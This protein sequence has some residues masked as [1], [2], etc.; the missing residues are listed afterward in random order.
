[1][2]ASHYSMDLTTGQ[3]FYFREK[4]TN[5]IRWEINPDDPNKLELN[6][7]GSMDGLK[8]SNA[9]NIYFGVGG[10]SPDNAKFINGT[11][12]TS[13]ED[14]TYTT[15]KELTV[16]T[17]AYG[18]SIEVF[19]NNANDAVAGA[20]TG[21]VLIFT[22]SAPSGLDTGYASLGYSAG[23]LDNGM[24]TDKNEDVT[25]IFSGSAGNLPLKHNRS[26]SLFMGDVV[27]SG[28]MAVGEWIYHEGQ[29]LNALTRTGI[30]LQDRSIKLMAA[31][32]E[33]VHADAAGSV[34]SFNINPN[35]GAVSFQAKGNGA[36]SSPIF[37]A[38]AH[39]TTN[40]AIF[41][42][43]FDVL[44][45]HLNP[46]NGDDVLLFFSGSVGSKYEPADDGTPAVRATALFGGDVYV[47][48]ALG[49][50]TIDLANLT[51]TNTNA[52]LRFYDANHYIQ[53][54]STNLMFRDDA[55]GTAKSLTQLASLAVS[56]DLFSV[57]RTAV[58][59]PNY[60]M[61]T[62]SFSFDSGFNGYSTNNPR[63]TNLVS[64]NNTGGGNSDVYFFV[65]GAIG[66]R[67]REPV[68]I[69]NQLNRRSIALFG[70]DV[71]ISGTITSDNTSFGGSLNT[72]YDTSDGGTSVAGGGKTIIADAGYIEIKKTVSLPI[73]DSK[74]FG[75][76]GSAS[77]GQI[78]VAPI[79]DANGFYTNG[80]VF[81]TGSAGQLGF[82][83]G[84]SALA[85][86]AMSINNNNNLMMHSD[87]GN[88]RK[89][90]WDGAEASAFIRFTNTNGSNPGPKI[91][92]FANR[93][94]NGRISLSMGASGTTTGA[95]QGTGFEGHLA[96]SGSIVPGFDSEYNLGSPSHRWANVYT[97]DLH[98]K[99]DRGNWTIYEEPDMLVVVNN[100]TGKKY[101]MGLT[102]LED[103]E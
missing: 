99:N 100:M 17:T 87:S 49:A 58:G 93:N 75:V 70:G 32:T 8:L 15:T 37:S 74:L 29:E 24:F 71:H 84:G 34:K 35:N 88:S 77:F 95:G 48:G 64:I 65:S 36:G 67:T 25:L 97:G 60:G 61:S 42:N 4:V 28:S 3:H 63:P 9:K 22:S 56:D 72:A 62:G 26:T 47:S 55:L 59:V 44:S 98:L 18:Q 83:V 10:A 50:G 1:M 19:A 57:T 80:G 20:G 16:K 94:T 2:S 23:E 66:M 7:M 101:K 68:A 12:Q 102:P 39:D 30:R 53:K 69:V 96:V 31:G 76:T 89:I 45:P 82:G 40:R 41:H 21:A 46:A 52:Y 91:L 79:A 90:S 81:V 13:D 51:L 11:G 33:I 5:A 43:T 73:A 54:S 92:H 85:D 27:I 78:K 86:M 103:D 14:L 6:M 38:V